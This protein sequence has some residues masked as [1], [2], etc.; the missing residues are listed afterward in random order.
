M[1][2]SLAALPDFLS[3]WAR[4]FFRSASNAVSMSPSASTSAF[5]QSII[6]APVWS[7]KALTVF[8]SIVTVAQAGSTRGSKGYPHT[9][10]R[11][12]VCR[13]LHRQRGEAR[14]RRNRA[15]RCHRQHERCRRL[16]G[17]EDESAPKH[18]G[19]SRAERV[20]HGRGET[21]NR[22]VDVLL[23]HLEKTQRRGTHSP[24]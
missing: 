20:P 23:T 5:L 17:D 19:G 10:H 6:P 15:H 22:R 8:A 1:V 4:P 7:R 13:T 3:T 12:L 24:K 16:D 14:R 21:A 2:P 11:Q 9:Q 18:G